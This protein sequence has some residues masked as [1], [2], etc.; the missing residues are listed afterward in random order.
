MTDREQLEL[1]AT[2]ET[3]AKHLRRITMVYMKCPDKC[4]CNGVCEHPDLERTGNIEKR[5][6]DMSHKIAAIKTE[7]EA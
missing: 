4:L 6:L 3:A 5:L 1:I 2:L 7:D